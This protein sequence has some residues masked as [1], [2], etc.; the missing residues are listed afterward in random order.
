MPIINLKLNK[1]TKQKDGD[2]RPDNP[3]VPGIIWFKMKLKEEGGMEVSSRVKEGRRKSLVSKGLDFSTPFV[4]KG[5]R[6]SVPP[7]DSSKSIDV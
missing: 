5:S 6:R 1:I 4:P 3:D 7:K 2:T